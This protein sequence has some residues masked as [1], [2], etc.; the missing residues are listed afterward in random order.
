MK[1]LNIETRN[2]KQFS[3]NINSNVL[4]GFEFRTFDI[5]ICFKFRNSDFDVPRLGRD[6]KKGKRMHPPPYIL[7]ANFHRQ[8]DGD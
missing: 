8:R 5:R 2:P 7:L 6:D 1:N 3:K 4:N